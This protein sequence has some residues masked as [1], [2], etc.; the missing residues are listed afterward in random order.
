MKKAKAKGISKKS[1]KTPKTEVKGK[2][3]KDGLTS[4][5]RKM[6]KHLLSLG[7]S[8]QEGQPNIVWVMGRCIL[9][10]PDGTTDE[11]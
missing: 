11:L 9:V 7:G 4:A 3:K 5:Q 1:L 8:P 10:M 2:S 6:V